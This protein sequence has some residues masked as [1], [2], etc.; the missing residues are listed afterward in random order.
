MSFTFITVVAP[1]SLSRLTLA[2]SLI[3]TL[4][5]PATADAAAALDGLDDGDGVHFVSL[6]ALAAAD[7]AR[8]YLVLELSSDGT[9]R[10]A[11]ARLVRAI[12]NQ[13][14]AVF[15]L[16]ADWDGRIG[17]LDYLARHAARPSNGWRGSPGV[18]FS[19][20]PG[21]T[22]GRIRAEAD[23]VSHV[24]ELVEAQAAQT[25]ALER[26]AAIRREVAECFPCPA[27]AGPAPTTSE[28]M[29]GASP[30]V[31]IQILTSFSRTYLWPA[32]LALAVWVICAG[33]RS[34][35]P[36]IGLRPAA[37]HFVAGAAS[38]LL[39][40]I[41]VSLACLIGLALLTYVQLRRLERR[42]WV[43]ER[44]Q[45]DDALALMFE[46]E[47]RCAQNHMLSITERK[48]GVVRSFTARMAFWLIGELVGRSFE[49]GFLGPIGTIHSARWITVPGTRTLLFFS[50]YDGSWE[51]YL[52]DFIKLAH[53]GLTA[54]W[55]NSAGFPRAENLFQKGA[56]DGE[57]FKRYARRSMIPT[58]FWYSAYP[59][60]T[61]ARIRRNAR[62]T[63]GLRT[64]GSEEEARDWL[65]LFGSESR[66]AER[67]SA[68]KSRASSSV[69]SA[70][71]R[72]AH[73]CSM[74]CPQT[75]WRRAD[76]CRTCHRISRSMTAGIS[77]LRS[78]HAGARPRGAAP[79][80]PRRRRLQDLSVRVSPGHGEFGTKP[81]FGRCRRQRAGALALGPESAGRRA[82]CIWIYFR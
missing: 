4:G 36:A 10:V 64:I 57:R 37:Q 35:W 34:A 7:A 67:S 18:V 63:Q 68:T 41:W 81:D 51:S 3:S 11:L 60:L 77:K 42:D 39:S 48:P 56:T 33:V 22:V 21:L 12:G 62:I 65:T 76:G 6:N 29:P 28:P 14:G 43:D 26:V 72:S 49:P 2:E 1:L 80:G 69:A 17:L 78:R 46:R 59:S 66:P 58:Q 71:C 55:S 82:A 53:G 75:R 8:G 20:N 27:L 45:E 38:G 79:A 47:N 44:A 9:E 70:S 32:A 23:F 74:T 16:A 73:A 31:I 30:W 52:E 19:G 25:G 24:A 40:G 5:N 13:L 61:A 54:V 50:N 15:A